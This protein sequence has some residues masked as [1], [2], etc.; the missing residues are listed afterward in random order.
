[1]QEGSAS[2]TCL[3]AQPV[4]LTSLLCVDLQVFKG[5]GSSEDPSVGLDWRLLTEILLSV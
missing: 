5:L 2:G 3:H 4:A 1:M